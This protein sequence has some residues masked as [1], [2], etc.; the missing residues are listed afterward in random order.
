MQNLCQQQFHSKISLFVG[1][2][3]ERLHFL[4]H[5]RGNRRV[6]ILPCLILFQIFSVL[7]ID[8]G[9]VIDSPKEKYIVVKKL[10][11]GGFGAVYKVHQEGDKTKEYAL[12]V[13]K[14]NDKRT[15]SKLKMEVSYTL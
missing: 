15:H 9:S 3:S 5:E 8:V 11:E 14:K 1:C 4:Q 12:K 10:G 6:S 13:E 7:G 2:F